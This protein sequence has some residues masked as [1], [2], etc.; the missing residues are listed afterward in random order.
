MTNLRL[1]AA[2]LLC[3]ATASVARAVAPASQPT[4]T[5]PTQYLLFDGPSGA[6]RDFWNQGVDVR[7]RNKG[8]DWRDTDG[9]AQGP[10]AFATASVTPK[11]APAAAP[12]ELDATSLVRRWLADGNTG[13][14]LRAADGSCA[15]ASREAADAARRPT[16]TVTTDRGRF[17]CPCTADA[18][19]NPSTYKSLGRNAAI[20]VGRGASTAALQFDLSAVVGDVRSAT[21]S[22]HPDGKRGNCTIALMRL[23]APRLYAGGGPAT[24]GLSKDFP[25]DAGIAKHPDVVY[26]TDFAGDAWRR[27]FVGDVR[28]PTFARDE[29]LRSTFLRGRF[30][31]GDLGSCSLAYR[32]TAHGK[33]EPEEAYFRYYVYLEDDWGSTV[34]GNKMPGLAGRYGRWDGKKWNPTSGNG[35][36]RTTGRAT[37]TARGEDLSG[38]SMRAVGSGEPDDDNPY[39]EFT[40]VHTYAYHA[41]QAG[42][43]GD[44]WR[45]GTTVLA[46]GRWYCVEQ[47]V[48]LNTIDGPFDALGNGTGRRDGVLRAWVD[49]VQVLERT[50]VRFRHHPKIKLDEVWLNWYHGGTK[51]AEATHHYRMSNV[52]VARSYIGPMGTE[53][54][55]QPAR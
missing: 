53:A 33:P 36:A 32:W 45:W 50:D 40:P 13:A 7:W 22:L 49:G 48:R 55:S 8:G 37:E 21:L 51:P 19:L 18:T 12:V 15:F 5:Q 31:K 52:V 27:D 26:A 23:D 28:E 47:F 25:F 30:T 34:E 2:L 11:D 9:A 42:P 4:T 38:W 1:T 39:R 44:N 54:A 14:L 20:E 24:P 17:E 41:D 6:S 46:R 35:G 10:A 16:L 43:F 29:S 3:A